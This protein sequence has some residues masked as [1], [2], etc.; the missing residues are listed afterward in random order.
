LNA[1]NSTQLISGRVVDNFI[2]GS[3]DIGILLGSFANGEVSGNQLELTDGPSIA[4]GVQ[5]S[6]GLGAGANRIARN[7]ITQDGGSGLN[8]PG[9]TGGNQV[10]D[11]VI[12]YVGVTPSTACGICVDFPDSFFARNVVSGHYYGIRV[13]DAG[14]HFEQNKAYG[15]E[16]GLY[17]TGGVDNSYRDNVLIGNTTALDGGALGSAIDGGG[18][19]F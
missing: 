3:P 2:S 17:F 10:V 16:F 18:N 9:G 5:D 12:R 8:F 11:N 6:Y 15:N 14:N 4:I 19:L 7:R 13:W 1:H